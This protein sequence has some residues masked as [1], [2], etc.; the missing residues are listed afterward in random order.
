MQYDGRPVV[1][2]WP[3]E[4]PYPRPRVEDDRDR[5][6]RFNGYDRPR[7]GGSY[8]PQPPRRN[9]YRRSHTP[10][11]PQRPFRDDRLSPRRSNRDRSPATQHVTQRFANEKWRPDEYRPPNANAPH[12]VP[13]DDRVDA[14][15]ITDSEEQPRWQQQ[16]QQRRSPSPSEHNQLPTPSPRQEEVEI[17]L[18]DRINMEEADNRARGRGR[19]PGIMRGGPNPRRGL[20]GSSSGRGR[21]VVSEPAPALLSRMSETAKRSTRP[22]PAPSLSDRMQQD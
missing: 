15:R 11:P 19:P 4:R 20:R 1:D 2:R 16:V 7:R 10:P 5:P 3:P 17:G 21:G 13:A 14:R 12:Y 9:A 8:Q 22:A 6:R 18:L